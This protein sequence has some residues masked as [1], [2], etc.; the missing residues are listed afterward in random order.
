MAS[1]RGKTAT[2]FIDD[3]CQ[4]VVRQLS[5]VVELYSSSLGS[6]RARS[7]VV[8]LLQKTFR[9]SSEAEERSLQSD[10]SS[11]RAGSP[12]IPGRSRATRPCCCES[13]QNQ[14]LRWPPAA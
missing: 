12:V 3:N 4:S 9:R 14:S 10:R 13:V 7:A 1:N 5:M 6:D 8:S 2:C 11:V